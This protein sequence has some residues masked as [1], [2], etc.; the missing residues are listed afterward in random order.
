MPPRVLNVR[1]WRRRKPVSEP[2]TTWAWQ[3]QRSEGHQIL[4]HNCLQ[5]YEGV[6]LWVSH[7]VSAS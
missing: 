1:L 4:Q 7:P 2:W 5:K 3:R 6:A